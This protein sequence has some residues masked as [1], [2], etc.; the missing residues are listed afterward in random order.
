MRRD[1]SARGSPRERTALS[2]PRSDAPVVCT[3]APSRRPGGRILIDY[4]E[5]NGIR[6][7]CLSEGAGPLV[8]LLHGFPDTAHT[9]DDVRPRLAAK[10]YRAVSPFM[11]GY[12]PTSIPDRD[13][14]SETLAKDVLALIVALGEE[15]AIV[16]GHDWGA[17][18]AYGA[19]TLGPERVRKL[20][21]LAIPHPATLRPTPGKVWGVR[22]FFGYRLPGAPKRF[23]K[24]GFA[25]LPRIVH[26]WSPA[27]DPPEH[28][29]AAVRECFAHEASLNAAFGYY[30]AFAFPLPK[31]FQE[32][33]KVP[34]VVF[35]GLED[36]VADVSDYERAARMFE[37]EYTIEQVPGGHFLHREHPEVFAERLLAHL[38]VGGT[39]AHG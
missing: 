15:S 31:F 27:W 9:W 30:R 4:V 16:V 21:V 34:T 6:F 35:A 8:L 7:A 10:G 25:A 19:A 12:H 24:N 29:L 20:F 13:A 26:R 28:E 23:A 1:A 5:A 22:H 2:R 3:H 33:I 14:D 37:S 36:S 17:T 39:P 38:W 11:R 18:A 32:T